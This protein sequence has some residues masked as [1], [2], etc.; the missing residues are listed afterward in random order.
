MQWVP[1]AIL[2]EYKSWGVKLTTHLYLAGRSGMVE[3]YHF[4]EWFIIN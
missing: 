3:I 2:L 4:K 1:G